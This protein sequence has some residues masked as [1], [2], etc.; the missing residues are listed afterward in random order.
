M[1][2]KI[3][4]ALFAGARASSD[5]NAVARAVSTG[6]VKPIAKRIVNK[7]IGKHIVSKLWWR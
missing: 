7:M 4:R 2:G 5:A 6:S 1:F 3:S